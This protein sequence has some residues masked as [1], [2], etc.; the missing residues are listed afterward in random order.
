MADNGTKIVDDDPPFH[1]VW[2]MVPPDSYDIKFNLDS[3]PSLKEDLE[4]VFVSQE[5][6]ITAPLSG[7]EEPNILDA[8]YSNHNK[9]LRQ[10]SL[11]H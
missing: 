3:I 6:V 8:F 2:Q 7:E 1:P 9:R 5:V 4:A 10:L 11:F